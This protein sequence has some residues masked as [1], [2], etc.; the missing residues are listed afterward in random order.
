MRSAQMPSMTEHECLRMS[1]TT[2]AGLYPATATLLTLDLIQSITMFSPAEAH[3]EESELPRKRQ[4]LVISCTECHRRK[5][6]VP[7][8]RRRNSCPVLQQAPSS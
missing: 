7:T 8:K 5:Q 4:R 3:R 2:S 6:K 1:S